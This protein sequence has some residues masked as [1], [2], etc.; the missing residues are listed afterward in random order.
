MKPLSVILDARLQSGASGGV[1][2]VVIGL[3]SGLSSLTDS[4]ERYRFLTYEGQDDWLGPFLAGPCSA[5]PIAAPSAPDARPAW[6]RA[7]SR[8][9]PRPLRRA[10]RRVL[11]PTLPPPPSDGTIEAAGADL[12][13]FTFQNGFLTAVPSIYH[14]HDLQHLHLPAYFDSE[15]RRRREVWYRAL[16]AQA[17]MVAVTSS[18]TRA[19]VVEHYALPPD[20]VQVV[21]LAPVIGAYEPPGPAE[22]RSLAAR[23]GVPAAFA[24]YP[25]QTWPHKNHLALLDALALL[26]REQDLIVPLVCT[27]AHNAFFPTIARR[28]AELGLTDQV[29]FLGFVSPRELRALYA[30]ARAV[31][32]PSLFEAA[33]APLWEA[34]LAGVPAACSNVTSLPAQAGDAALVFDPHDVRGIADAV[35]RLWRDEPLRT[36]LVERGALRVRAFTW[37][38]TARHFRAH[39]RRLTG[40][41]LTDAD[42]AVLAAPPLL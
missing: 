26:R 30:L 33:S 29:V 24:L 10:A 37:D 9:T 8:L 17:A 38:R 5:L 16:C 32:V 22:A 3:A 20:K 23:L 35:A 21:P 6:R 1:E 31:V 14:P 41:L 12:M 36:A 2:S 42:R 19:D 4:D 34:F 7:A 25:A 15:E 28:A 39:Y 13:H 40:R 18:A 11:R 27:G